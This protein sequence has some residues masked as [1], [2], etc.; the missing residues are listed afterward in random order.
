M[1]EGLLKNIF[2]V[3]GRLWQLKRGRYDEDMDLS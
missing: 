1:I 3:F 2:I